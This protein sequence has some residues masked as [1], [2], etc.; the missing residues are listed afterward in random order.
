MDSRSNVAA[1]GCQE[2]AADQ[3]RCCPPATRCGY[4][5]PPPAQNSA[6]PAALGQVSVRARGGNS[7]VSARR[8]TTTAGCRPEAD[9]G[10]PELLARKLKA[11]NGWAGAVEL[12]DIG[13]IMFAHLLVTSEELAQLR[14]L[15]GWLRQVQIAFHLKTG[16][17]S[18]LWAA[19]LGGQRGSRGWSTPPAHPRTGEEAR[20]RGLSWGFGER[21]TSGPRRGLSLGASELACVTA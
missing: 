10:S 9:R 8:A 15:A 3:R 13:G 21:F 16:S 7:T 14:E 2:R 19:I 12:V 11:A 1:A 17:P 6:R 5:E 18:G 4:E 20:P